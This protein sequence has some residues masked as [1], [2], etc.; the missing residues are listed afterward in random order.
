MGVSQ[1]PFS[2]LTITNIR[3]GDFVEAQFNPSTFQEDISVNYARPAVL[4][5]SH[6]PM[7]YLGTGNMAIPFELFFLSR[8]V[9]THDNLKVAKN[10]LHSLC[11]PPA[12]AETI[13]AGQ[14]PRALVAWPNVV[15]LT[16]KIIQLSV[17]LTRFNIRNEP[18]QMTA[19][20]KFE[21]MRDVRWTSE[22]AFL[23]GSIRTSENPGGSQ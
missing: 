21:E 2:R 1:T 22:D 5:L 15:S 6:Q 18:V 8:D 23:H 9:E 12:G 4:G 13:V 17:R 14:P 11:Y 19:R 16:C 20:C 10:F 7:Q 3:T